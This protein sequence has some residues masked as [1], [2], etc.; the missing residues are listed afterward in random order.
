VPPNSQ[1]STMNHQLK[2]GRARV[3]EFQYT[4]NSFV[5]PE[6]VQF[7]Y[8]LEGHDPDWRDA[9]NRRVAYYT[10]LAPG[11]YQ[12]HVKA[13]NNHGYWNE[14]GDTF[15]FYLMPHLYQTWVFY[16]LCAAAVIGTGWGLHLLRLNV[17]HKVQELHAAAG[18]A[19]QR[20]RFAQDMHDDIGASLTEIA[21]LSEVARKNANQPAIA[22]A[23]SGKISTIAGE[24]VNN[25]SELIW[26]TN[27]KFDTLE[28]FVAY[29]REYVGGYLEAASIPWRLNFPAAVPSLHLTS[30]FRRNLFLVVK[31]ALHN[32]IKHSTAS[33]V[34]VGLTVDKSQLELWIADNGRGF[35][36]EAV[37]PG[38]NGLRN[39][40]QRVTALGGHFDLQSPPMNGT[41]ISITVPLL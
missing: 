27:P 7:K 36:A 30:E 4:A 18:L 32:I 13:C 29:L 23:Q 17:V 22:E 31:E 39:M 21:L 11:Q 34:E 14:T 2:P 5:A 20:A 8:R 9:G 3:M 12:F 41:K 33:E 15:A 6:K 25:L 35:S 16:V 1:P 38:G 26:A 19:E 10:D 24:M 37:S 28:N 40:R